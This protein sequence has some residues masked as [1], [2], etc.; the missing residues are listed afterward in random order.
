M[1]QRVNLV[2][3]FLEQYFALASLFGGEYLT[4]MSSSTSDDE[5]YMRP[6]RVK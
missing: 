3:P 5:V 4:D 1:I 2:S 6:K